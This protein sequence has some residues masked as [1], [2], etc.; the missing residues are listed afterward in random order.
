MALIARTLHSLGIHGQTSPRGRRDIYD[1]PNLLATRLSRSV[2]PVATVPIQQPQMR[3]S[4]LYAF[5]PCLSR[6][7]FGRQHSS[8]SPRDTHIGRNRVIRICRAILTH[9]R[10]V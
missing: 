3:L 9:R 7:T 2:R 6:P 5:V 4:L 1:A 10:D 8:R